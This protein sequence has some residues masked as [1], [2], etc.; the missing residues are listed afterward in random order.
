MD[1][2][3]LFDALYTMALKTHRIACSVQYASS[4]R[5]SGCTAR[6]SV[7]DMYMAASVRY[8]MNA[9]I[10]FEKLKLEIDCISI[11]SAVHKIDHVRPI[12]AS[13]RARRALQS[14]MC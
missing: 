3:T 4:K 13:Y 10:F 1:G 14:G 2:Y 8:K 7:V 6:L 12:R 9:K 11:V 5:E